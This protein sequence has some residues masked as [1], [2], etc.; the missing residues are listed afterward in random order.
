V[1]PAPN[2][3]ELSKAAHQAERQASLLH[4]EEELLRASRKLADALAAPASD[5]KAQRARERMVAAA[6][7]D[8]EL[9]QSAL[10]QATDGYTP[11]G[12][13]YPKTTSGRRLALARWIASRENPLTARV[14]VNHI[15]LRHF[16]KALVPTVANFGRNGRPPTHPELL[17]WL[18]CELMDRGWSM[19]T[20]HRLIVTSNTYRMQS[21]VTD[22]KHPN[23]AL[24]GENRYLWHMNPRRMEAEVVR[25]STMH[26]AGELDLTLGGPEIDEAMGEI[27]RR[28]S[29]YFKSTP[30]AQMLFLKLFDAPDPRDCYERT[31]SVVPQ[32][33]LALSNS[34]LSRTMARL[35]AR[36]LGLT[37]PTAE[38]VDA[39]FE[40]VLGRL[41]SPVEKKES[42]G[43]LAQQAELFQDPSK[44]TAFKT[45]TA[46]EVP[47]S[48]D[49]DARA[50]E[51]L[52]HVLLNHNEFVVIR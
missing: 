28:R 16:G 20:L 43:F 51:N 49:P 7:R 21:A 32:Q 6:R 13:M 52:V 24:D 38:F 4:A 27:S 48:N 5:D 17:D 35:L 9:A 8:L 15:W 11:L 18:A 3:E 22:P 31:D 23:V 41:P 39:A 42:E 29:F 37:G 30:D 33:A 50:R 1:P 26:V 10:N 34:K 47:P 40:T 2:A 45:G 19:K 36:R 12:K 44:L 14:A 25:D 46:S